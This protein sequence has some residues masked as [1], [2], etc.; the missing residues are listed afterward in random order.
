MSNDDSWSGA[1]KIP[2]MVYVPPPDA[3]APAGRG[4][5]IGLIVLLFT[6]VA[7]VVAGLFSLENW[8]Y[9]KNLANPA[10]WARFELDGGD[11]GLFKDE[12]AISDDVNP[13]DLRQIREG[14]RA[15]NRALCARP[16]QVPEAVPIPDLVRQ[17]DETRRRYDAA[18]QNASP[19]C[20]GTTSP[21]APTAIT[22]EQRTT[23]C[24]KY[25]SPTTAPALNQQR[26]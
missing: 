7:I 2:P 6:I 1:D 9:S 24:T 17:V 11:Y 8:V 14:L 13:L 12:R 16:T 20:V 10:N 26:Q 19:Q 3:D 5:V 15:Q 21:S 22:A 25:P 23:L 18:C 4:G